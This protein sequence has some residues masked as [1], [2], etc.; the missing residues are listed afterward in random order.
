METPQNCVYCHNN[1]PLTAP[2]CGRGMKMAQEVAAGT[3]TAPV[4]GEENGRHA[5]GSHRGHHGGHG[6]G[7]GHGR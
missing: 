5:D 2:K 7:H 3:W 6:H 4:E 1:C